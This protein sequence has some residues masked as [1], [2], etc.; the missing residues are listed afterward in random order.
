[1]VKGL[2]HVAIAVPDV[3]E[4]AKFYEGKLGLKLSGKE[5]VPGRKVTVGFIEVGNTRIELVQPDSPDSPIAKFLEQRGPGLQHICLEVDDID[6]EFTRLK[7][8]GVRMT[9]DA[10][11]PGAHGTKVTFIHPSS[12]GGVLVELSQPAK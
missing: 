8:A 1:M 7:A 11:R 6:A 5:S 10:P 12:T 9:D 3:D 2:A 4:A